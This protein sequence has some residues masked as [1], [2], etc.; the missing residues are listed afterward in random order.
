MRRAEIWWAELPQPAGERPVV[1]LT[2]NA[3]IDTIG[4]VVVAL[5]TRTNRGLPTE[6]AVG[7]QEGLPRPSVVNLDAILTVPR[8]RL[9]RQMGQLSGSKVEELDRGLKVSLG[10]A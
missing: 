5:V 4:G 3:V 9:V 2:R 1:V 8:Q 6:I 7:R 10:L